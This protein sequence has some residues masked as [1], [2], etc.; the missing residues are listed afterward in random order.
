MEKSRIVRAVCAIEASKA[1]T[2]GRVEKKEYNHSVYRVYHM[3]GIVV[4][5]KGAVGSNM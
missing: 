2:K 5:K 4:R 3:C 1:T